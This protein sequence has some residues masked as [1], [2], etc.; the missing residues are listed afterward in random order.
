[1]LY[2]Q[3]NLYDSFKPDLIKFGDIWVILRNVFIRD[4][5]LGLG[6]SQRKLTTCS[7]KVGP[8]MLAAFDVGLTGGWKS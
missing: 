5:Q 7:K 8:K 3:Q 1:M 2:Q 4:Y 6:I